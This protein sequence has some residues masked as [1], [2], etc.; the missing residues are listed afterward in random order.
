MVCAYKVD[1]PCF[2]GPWGFCIALLNLNPSLLS[3]AEVDGRISARS[4]TGLKFYDGLT[5]QGIFSL[6]RYLRD[7]LSRQTRLIADNEPL[8]IYHT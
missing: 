7:A 4:L 1:M 6:P 2:G 3:P 5:H 8:F